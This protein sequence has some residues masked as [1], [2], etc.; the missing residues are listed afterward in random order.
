MG[1][2]NTNT[3]VLQY[4][5]QK[6]ITNSPQPVLPDDLVVVYR[7]IRQYRDPNDGLLN[8]QIIPKMFIFI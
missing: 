2:R 6:E 4:G 1:T 3:E 8:S 7:D 5:C